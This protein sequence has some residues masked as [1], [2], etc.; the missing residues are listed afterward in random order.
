MFSR[1]NVGNCNQQYVTFY[2]TI[3]TDPEGKQ[4]SQVGPECNLCLQA[5]VIPTQMALVCPRQQAPR[6]GEEI[7]ISYGDKSNEQLLMSYGKCFSALQ[8]CLM[9]S[10]VLLCAVLRCAALPC[11][12]FQQQL[13]AARKKTCRNHC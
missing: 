1:D 13:A 8:Y 4:C 10:P 11:C 2:D 12:V 6:P 3:Q 7:T 9:Q 5:S